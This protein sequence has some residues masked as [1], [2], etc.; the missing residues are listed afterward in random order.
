[1]TISK[2]L[3][4]ILSL[5]GDANPND[6]LSPDIAALYKSDRAA[7]D[8]KAREWTLLFAMEGITDDE[9]E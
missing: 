2:V 7:Y 8:I 9:F 5:L 6:P 3:L 4:S 1:L